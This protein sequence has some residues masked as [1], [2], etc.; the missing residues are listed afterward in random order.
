MKKNLNEQISR[1][2]EMMGKVSD[3]KFDFK[4][5]NPRIYFNNGGSVSIQASRSHYCEPRND[6]GPYSEME[7]GFPSEETVIIPELLDYMEQQEDANPHKSVYPYT[8]VSVI[9]KFIEANG[10]I[11]SGE[12]PPVA[13]SDP[14]AVNEGKSNSMENIDWEETDEVY[15]KVR[16]N[17]FDPDQQ[18][19]QD[20]YGYVLQSKIG[21]DGAINFMDVV[22][23]KMDD[24]EPT[25]D[26][27]FNQGNWEGGIKG[28]R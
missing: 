5:T 9:K 18:I 12:L 1:I 4:P 6:K 23:I 13:E 20:Y 22:D 19:N 14:E 24:R 26:Q 25:D 27:I 11:E 7:L 8:P 17:H 2:Q 3:E 28:E 16:G 21:E 10:G 15:V